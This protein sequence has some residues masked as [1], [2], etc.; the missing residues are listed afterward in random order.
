MGESRQ[1]IIKIPHPLCHLL[2]SMAVVIIRLQLG[3]TPR[4][5]RKDYT[6]KDALMAI[7]HPP[8]PPSSGAEATLLTAISFRNCG[9]NEQHCE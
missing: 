4:K 3:Q 6:T 2:Y 1:C 5:G 9:V 7:Q 8:P